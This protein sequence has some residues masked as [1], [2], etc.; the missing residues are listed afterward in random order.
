M[1]H[2]SVVS[3]SAA[4]ETFD[5]FG[6]PNSAISRA[7]WEAAIKM[8]TVVA[9]DHLHQIKNID[10]LPICAGYNFELCSR[11]FEGFQSNLTPE[12]LRLLEEMKALVVKF[13]ERWPLLQ[14]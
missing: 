1:I 2:Q 3:H 6:G 10:I 7:A 13:R 4:E 11:H 5:K 8:M 9:S 12:E 14:R